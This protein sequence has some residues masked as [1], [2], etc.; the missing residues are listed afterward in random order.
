LGDIYEN[1]EERREEIK[2]ILLKE[3]KQFGETL[4][5]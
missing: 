4:E 5:K 3:E 1:L 2:V